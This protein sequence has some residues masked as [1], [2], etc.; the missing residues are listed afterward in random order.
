MI[1]T[2]ILQN[3]TCTTYLI[4]HLLRYF[5]N[6][7]NMEDKWERNFQLSFCKAH[8]RNIISFSVMK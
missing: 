8:R 2:N 7:M 1:E 5:E 3:H 4:P 6:K